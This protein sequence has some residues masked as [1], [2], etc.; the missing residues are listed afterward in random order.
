MTDRLLTCADFPD[1]E[2]C[3][4]C[5]EPPPE[6]MHRLYDDRTEECGRVCCG[7][8][9]APTFRAWCDELGVEP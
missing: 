5:H 2:C 1:G 3:R 7:K 9:A 4:E 6:P 8:R